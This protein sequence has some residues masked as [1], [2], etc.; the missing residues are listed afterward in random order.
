[1]GR[2][3]PLPI[4]DWWAAEAAADCRP[5]NLG[6]GRRWLDRRSSKPRPPGARP[7]IERRS[8]SWEYLFVWMLSRRVQVPRTGAAVLYPLLIVK[9]VVRDLREGRRAVQPPAHA[10]DGGWPRPP[11]VWNLASVAA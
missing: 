4:R 2:A 9:P 7:T 11:P 8:V 10:V 1:M 3:S 5:S 6:R